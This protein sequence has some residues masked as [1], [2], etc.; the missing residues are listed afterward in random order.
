MEEKDPH[1]SSLHSGDDESGSE[2]DDES[3]NEE[4]LLLSSFRSLLQRAVVILW[5]DEDHVEQEMINTAIEHSMDTYHESLFSL[6]PDRKTNL[7][8]SVLTEDME[9]ICHICLDPMKKG[10]L[11]RTLS[12][13]HVFH[14]TCV[15]ELVVHQHIV[16]PLCRKSIPIEKLETK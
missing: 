11:V 6:D 5:R 3:G 4:E 15:D 9:D 16:C 10:D 2:S 7:P 12:C 13:Q 8:P 14:S 1:D